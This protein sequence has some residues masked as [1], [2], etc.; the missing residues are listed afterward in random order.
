M[1]NLFLPSL[2]YVK[3]GVDPGSGEPAGEASA[4]PGARYDKV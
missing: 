1:P 4:D 3:D 2:S